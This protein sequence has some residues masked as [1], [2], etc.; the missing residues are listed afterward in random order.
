MTAF[1]TQLAGVAMWCRGAMAPMRHDH[2]GAV[3]HAHTAPV[4]SANQP[5]N[6]TDG[7]QAHHWQNVVHH[8]DPSKVLADPSMPMPI[9][10]A[11]M[12]PPLHSAHLS[13]SQSTPPPTWLQPRG[14]CQLYGR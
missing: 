14:R 5:A 1:S 2:R 6:S 8:P 11:P 4:R 10:V 12:L 13:P 3:P 7:L 9:F